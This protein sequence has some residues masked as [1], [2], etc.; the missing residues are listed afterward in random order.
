MNP[1]S[2]RDLPAHVQ[3]EMIAHRREYHLR[4]DHAQQVHEIVA[5][6]EAQKNNDGKK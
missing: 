5:K 2:F 4:K 3:V 1:E 6:I